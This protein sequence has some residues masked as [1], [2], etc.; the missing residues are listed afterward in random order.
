MNKRW[1][2]EIWRLGAALAVATIAGLVVDQLLP[3][4][5]FTLVLYLLFHVYYLNRLLNWLEA[6]GKTYPPVGRGI[7]V[8]IFDQL[9]RLQKRNQA[10]KKKLTGYLNRF[11]ESTAAM[12]DATVVLD[13]QWQI[14]W[15]NAAAQELLGLNPQ[16]DIAQHIANLIRNPVFKDYLDRED[17]SQPLEINSPKNEEQYVSIRI[18]RYS[19]DRRLFIARDITRIIRLEQMRR[20]FVGNVSHELRTP[21]TVL[22]GY[23]ETIVDDP[24]DALD[25]WRHSLK[26]MHQQAKRMSNIVNDLLMLSRLETEDAPADSSEVSVPAM[27]ATIREDAIALSGDNQHDIRLETDPDVWLVGAGNELHSALSNITFNAVRYTPAK[28][29]ITLR[30]YVCNTG[31]ARLEVEDTGIGIPPQHISRLT[32]RFYRVDVGRSREVGG[33]GLGLAIVKYVLQR[34]KGTLRIESTVN[35]GSTF[36]CEFAAD[37]V[38]MRSNVVA[39]AESS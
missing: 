13:E 32:E 37:R 24:D 31:T 26:L 4:L 29:R 19:N 5:L 38:V 11:Q 20:D 28:G 2:N 25:E 6:R 21:L 12:P 15:I 3:L 7:W 18:I 30:W 34:H 1:A 27:L 10:R 36:I 35:K 39:N 8:E 14:E 33:T 17:F 9:R 22:N 16:Q 23:L